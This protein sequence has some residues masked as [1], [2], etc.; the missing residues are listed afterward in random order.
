MHDTVHDRA[1]M[2]SRLRIRSF[3]A[4]EVQQR[5]R[6]EGQMSS[7]HAAPVAPVGGLVGRVVG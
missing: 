2:E 7:P 6:L 5:K 4:L 3:A 1:I